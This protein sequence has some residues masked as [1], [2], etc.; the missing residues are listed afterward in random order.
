M[1]VDVVMSKIM[2]IL[3]LSVQWL[4]MFMSSW[5]RRNRIT[6]LIGC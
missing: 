5:N 6:A 3:A 2:G 1:N 4:V